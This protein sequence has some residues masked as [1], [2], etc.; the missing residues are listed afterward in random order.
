MEANSEIVSREYLVILVS[1]II[2]LNKFNVGGAAILADNKRNHHI[3]SEGV[4]SIN[5]FVM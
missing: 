4:T 1:N 5:P 2:S 3:D